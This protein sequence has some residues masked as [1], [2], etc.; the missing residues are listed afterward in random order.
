VRKITVMTFNKS[1]RIAI[2]GSGAV[3]CYYGARLAQHGYGV[4]FLMRSDFEHVSTHGLVIKSHQGDF[5]LPKVQCYK[6][7]EGIGS[8]DLV[9]IALKSTANDSLPDLLR[10]LLHEN[11]AVLTL[12]NG[13][14]NEAFLSGLIRKD[15]ILGGLCFVCINRLSAGVIDHSAQGLI[16]I[17]EYAGEPTARTHSI[18]AILNASQIPCKVEPSLGLA[19]WRK[20]VWNIPFNG[21]SI[22]AGGLDTERIL[23]SPA[24]SQLV[25]DLMHEVIHVANHLGYELPLSLADDMIANTRGMAAYKTSSLID[26][27]AGREVE[28]D[29]IWL[30]PCRQ[31]RDAGK[32]MPKVEM[33][34]QLIAACV[35][36]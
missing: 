28:L 25:K 8:C 23:A 2:V 9:I 19:R 10:P 3:G 21:L 26:Y 29:S 24:L 34:A 1:S 4:H 27:M 7:P 31:A 20:L 6:A 16:T 32:P 35:G 22:A 14:G 15:Q 33:L 18:A 17:G 13:L 36:K 5:Q 12:Q 11:T 30:E